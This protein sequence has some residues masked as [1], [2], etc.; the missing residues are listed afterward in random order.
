MCDSPQHSSQRTT[1]CPAK[2]HSGEGLHCD[3]E[4]M[5]LLIWGVACRDHSWQSEL[6]QCLLAWVWG[7]TFGY[8]ILQSVPLEGT[9]T[10]TRPTWVGAG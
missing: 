2:C 6:V 10:A 7:L 3:Y 4:G 9:G 5:I 8:P 1:D